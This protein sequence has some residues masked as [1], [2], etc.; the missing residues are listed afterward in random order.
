MS[1]PKQKQTQ[2]QEQNVK[3]VI[4]QTDNKKKRRQRKKPQSQSQSQGPTPY[5]YTPA[6]QMRSYQT[7]TPQVNNNAAADFSSV[8]NALRANMAMAMPVQQGPQPIRNPPSPIQVPA[9]IQNPAPQAAAV[10]PQSAISPIQVPPIQPPPT[11][12]T[13]YTPPAP[14]RPS[15]IPDFPTGRLDMTDFTPMREL[16]Q[17]ESKLP[18]SESKKLAMPRGQF[19]AMDNLENLLKTPSRL[20]G[21]YKFDKPILPESR[22]TSMVEYNEPLPNLRSSIVFNNDEPVIRN[23][24]IDS[25]IPASAKKMREANT[26]TQPNTVPRRGRTKFEVSIQ[27]PIPISMEAGKDFPQQEIMGA[28]TNADMARELTLKL[29]KNG[30]PDKRTVEGRQWFLA[31]QA[32]IVEDP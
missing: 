8:V 29:T 17:T 13:M 20:K 16:P 4:N 30:L 14:A 24:P 1:K 28:K 12:P 22:A 18:Q 19:I 32:E 25:L 5:G 23:V 3:V 10:P 9:R 31:R 26:D 21:P 2:K 7:F 11:A 27:E 15:I 6:Q